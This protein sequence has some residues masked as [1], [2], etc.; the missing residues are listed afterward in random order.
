M[1]AHFDP[2]RKSVL[3]IDASDYVTAA[4]LSQYD[5]QN[6]L[7]PVVFMFK[8]M[9]PVECKYEIYDKKLLAI[10]RAFET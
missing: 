6:V 10:I 9:I 8:K 7:R 3:E 2:D 5:D 4:V 1:L